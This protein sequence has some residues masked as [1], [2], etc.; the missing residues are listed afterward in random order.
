M[1]PA[2]ATAGLPSTPPLPAFSL[3]FALY[4]FFLPPRGFFV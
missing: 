1:T 2:N 4:D 3:L